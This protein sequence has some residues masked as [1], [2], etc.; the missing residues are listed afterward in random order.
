MGDEILILHRPDR[1]FGLSWK[2]SGLTTAS[3]STLSISKLAYVLCGSTL[4]PLSTPLPIAAAQGG[5]PFTNMANLA[6]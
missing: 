2:L 3:P 6:F 1:R 4:N 5:L